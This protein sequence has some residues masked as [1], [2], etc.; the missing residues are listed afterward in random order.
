MVHRGPEWVPVAW[1]DLL[2]DV[3]RGR[4][5][6]AAGRRAAAIAWCWSRPIATNGS[7]A[8]LAIQMAQAVHVPVH[9][10]LAGPQIAYQIRASGAK[11]LI[12]S[13][14]EQAEK[15]RAPRRAAARAD[16]SRRLRCLPRG[17]RAFA[18]AALQRVAAR[19]RRALRP[20]QVQADAQRACSPAD[21]A[22]IL[23]TSGT[24]GEP[25]GVM[26]SQ[27]NLASN[28]LAAL[29]VFGRAKTIAG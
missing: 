26:L 28:A 29:E 20:Q 22:T 11:L 1:E 17:P 7:Y 16:A 23:Y 25:K 18:L 27:Q 12:I 2:A 9:A 21:L 19:R 6:A 14:E 4:G 3:R 8:D 24:T 13:G 15:L 10:S 5:L